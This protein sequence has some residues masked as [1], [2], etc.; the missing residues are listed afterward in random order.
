[1]DVDNDSE[2]Q[3]LVL[4]WNLARCSNEIRRSLAILIWEFLLSFEDE[5]QLFW[6]KPWTLV[7]Y[8]FYLSRYVAIFV[9]FF[10]VLV[11]TTL[12]V[13][14]QLYVIP[15]WANL[16]LNP[17]D[18]SLG[19][20]Q[21]WLIIEGFCGMISCWSVQ[22]ILQ[23]R[24]YALYERSIKIK[25]ILFSTFAAEAAIVIVIFIIGATRGT[26]VADFSGNQSR[27]KVVDVPEWMWAF[28]A[29]LVGY[30]CILCTLVVFKAY[31]RASIM[32]DEKNPIT[33]WSGLQNILIRDSVIYYVGI[34]MIYI[35]NMSFWIK[36]LPETFDLA[37]SIAVVY[38]SLIGCRLMINIRRVYYK[39]LS[40][41]PLTPSDV[42]LPLI[43]Q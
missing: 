23:L 6:D 5:R 21:I 25:R 31:E 18:V 33:S 10:G 29:T 24:L 28:W 27:C 43:L 19:L 7:S 40:Q 13:T 9:A 8:L 22:I 20:N 26:A 3:L 4:T 41:I 38:P 42:S 30:E 32:H 34:C 1:M 35:A 15:L 37:T 36:A 11:S 12:E 16:S 17:P 14:D 39:P 2:S